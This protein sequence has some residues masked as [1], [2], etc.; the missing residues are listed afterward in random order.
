VVT[1]FVDTSGNSIPLTWRFIN[2]IKAITSAMMLY[3]ELAHIPR[4]GCMTEDTKFLS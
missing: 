1:Q 4:M 2:L 3:T